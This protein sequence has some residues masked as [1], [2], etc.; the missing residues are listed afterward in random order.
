MII[1]IVQQTD[2]PFPMKNPKKQTHNDLIERVERTKEKS[3]DNEY[4]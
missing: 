1:A 2:V 3:K 4:K